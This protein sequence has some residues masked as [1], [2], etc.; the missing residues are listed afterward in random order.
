MQMIF[1]DPYA[2]LNPRWRVMDIVAE[3]I[4][5]LGLAKSP[6]EVGERVAELL[7]QVGLAREDREKY[8]HEFSG[9][10]ASAS[11]S[12]ARCR[13]VPSSWSAT[14]RLRRSTYRCRRRSST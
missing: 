11:R 9:G 14:S 6:A 7:V 3:P 5:V 1:Q 4:R 12:P 8:P 13:E 10:S 2:S